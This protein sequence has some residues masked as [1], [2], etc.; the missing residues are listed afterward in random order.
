MAASVT[1]DFAGLQAIAQKLAALPAARQA[2]ARG[3]AEEAIDLVRQGFADRTDPY[4]AQWADKADGSACFLVGPTGNLKSGWHIKE[5]SAD[6]VTVG[7]SVFYA[8]THQEGRTIKAK[9]V[10]TIRLFGRHP[11]EA[12]KLQF[13]IGDQWVMTDSV[14]I[15]QRRMVPDEGDLPPTWDEAIT[16]AAEEMLHELLT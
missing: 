16:E 5:V 15:P 7:P 1:G 8:I 13:K 9:N 4:G 14:T 2:L 10:R 11:I 12:A 3:I 6:E